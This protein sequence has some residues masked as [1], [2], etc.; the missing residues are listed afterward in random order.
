VLLQILFAVLGL[1]VLDLVLLVTLSKNF[2]FWQTLIALF[3]MGLLGSALARREGRRVW[4][5]FQAA[6]AEGRAPESGVVDGMLV[7]LG[8]VLMLLPGLL[9]D[10]I[11]VA[12]CVPPLRRPVAAF[13]RRRISRE[14]DLRSPRVDVGARRM[15]RTAGS[16]AA[17]SGA[18]EVIDTTG[19]ESPK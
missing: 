11:G 10:V 8:G 19:V 7:L 12:L 16:S 3:G 13:L 18:P 5:E 1:Q 4:R 17:P 9:S 6:L 14:L 2:G 15:T